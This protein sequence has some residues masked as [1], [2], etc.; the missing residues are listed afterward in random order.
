MKLVVWF[1]SLEQPR[2]TCSAL[3]TAALGNTAFSSEKGSREIRNHYIELIQQ[4]HQVLESARVL[5]SSSTH[6]YYP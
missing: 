5:L 1:S 6:A 4:E 3:Q 2:H